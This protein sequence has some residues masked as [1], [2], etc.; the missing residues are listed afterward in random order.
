M[1]L[2]TILASTL[3]ISLAAQAAEA[4]K[5]KI[6]F[7]TKSSGFEHDVISYKKGQ[8]SFAEQ[9][10]LE[11]GGANGWEFVFSK[12]GSKFSKGYLAQF[13]ALM[14]YTTGNLCEEGTDKQPAMTMEGKEAIFDF[15]RSGKGFVGTHSASDTFHTDNESQ[16][17]PE[18]YVNHCE[19]ADPYVRFLGGEFIKH[20]AQQVGRNIV[21][22]PKFPGFE[23]VGEE[24]GFL[25]EWYS[26]KDFSRDL[27][28][29]TVLD[30]PAM[31]GVEYER[32]KFP[33]T[34]ARKEGSGR[35]WY[36]SMGHREDV[37]TNPIFR[38]ILVGGIKWACGDAQGSVEPN[39]KEAAPEADQNPPYVPPKP[40]KAPK[41]EA[42]PAN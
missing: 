19:K 11:L 17:G 24:F 6:L 15:V 29:L 10:L 13:D 2:R 4:P 34:W 3:A 32:P 20:G 38:E 18:R 5:R 28:V 1:I 12:D 35:V 30:S 25:E 41:P 14:F 27:H 42:A 21:V 9:Q 8:P 40:P 36:T 7:F 22:D 33:N 26:L 39:L 23:K 31:K 37:W 16:K